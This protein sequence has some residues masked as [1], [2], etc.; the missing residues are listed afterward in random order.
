MV[1]ASID[2][3]ICI[4]GVRPCPEKLQNV[5]IKRISNLSWKI[6][7]ENKCAVTRMAVW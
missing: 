7:R 6:D 3:T 1:S 4:W 5:C 2:C